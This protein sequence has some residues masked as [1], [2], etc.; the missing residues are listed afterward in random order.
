[1]QEAKYVGGRKRF[2]KKGHKYW[3]LR[4]DSLSLECKR[5]QRNIIHNI[6]YLRT[7]ARVNPWCFSF[8]GGLVVAYKHSSIKKLVLKFWNEAP[9]KR[10]TYIRFSRTDSI[11][12]TFHSIVTGAGSKTWGWKAL[13][14]GLQ[15]LKILNYEGLK[16]VACLKAL[17]RRHYRF[18]AF[19]ESLEMFSTL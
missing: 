1:M 8:S 10:W 19:S 15:D 12:Q 7:S 14:T 18:S 13:E 4:G 6:R 9:I 5:S 16:P 11:G 2:V 3:S 17:K